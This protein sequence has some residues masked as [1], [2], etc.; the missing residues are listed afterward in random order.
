MLH[1]IFKKQGEHGMKEWTFMAK[2]YI[3]INT[4]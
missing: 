3:F 4:V 1:C 2:K